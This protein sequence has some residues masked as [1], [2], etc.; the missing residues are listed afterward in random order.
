[1]MK[2]IA[3]KMFYR[4]DWQQKSL[5]RGLARRRHGSEAGIGYRLAIADRRGIGVRATGP[6]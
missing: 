2:R 3:R 5:V 1:M 4:R 6:A